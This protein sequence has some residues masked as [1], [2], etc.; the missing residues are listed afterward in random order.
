MA[1]PK[2]KG[3]AEDRTKVKRHKH[4]DDKYYLIKHIVAERRTGAT[5]E[6][7]VDWAGTNEETGLPY[8][9]ADQSWVPEQD[10]T[11]LARIEWDKRKLPSETAPAPIQT[12]TS[13]SSSEASPKRGK[14]RPRKQPVADRANPAQQTAK[15]GR[16]RPRNSQREAIVESTT[17]TAPLPPSRDEPISH[18]PTSPRAPSPRVTIDP[19]NPSN[20]QNYLYISQLDPQSHTSPVASESSS[21]ASPSRA[22]SSFRSTGVVF[23]SESEEGE[24]E[25]NPSASFTPTTQTTDDISY[26]TPSQLY[27]SHPSTNEVSRNTPCGALFRS[28]T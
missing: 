21:P 16:G 17:S 9:E 13:A 5:L 26:V 25:F 6:Y 18:N 11:T 19:R 1:P 24:L 28:L 8:G 22:A 14:G 4:T 27:F 7:L 23:E 2:R 12:A 15:R 3:R 20:L 10:V